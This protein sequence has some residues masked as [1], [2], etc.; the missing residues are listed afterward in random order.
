MLGGL[1]LATFIAPSCIMGKGSRAYASQWVER[2]AVCRTLADVT[3][4]F[5]CLDVTGKD[6]R[7]GWDN[8]GNR[9]TLLTFPNG[10]WMVLRTLNSHGHIQGGTLITHDSTG[11]NRVFFGHVCGSETLKG[12]TMTEAYSNLLS[13][14]TFNRKEVF[15]NARR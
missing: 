12:N 8:A 9:L 10:G 11:T 5:E 6:G 14:G 7:I 13:I 4:R 15:L 1:G 2:L 3:N